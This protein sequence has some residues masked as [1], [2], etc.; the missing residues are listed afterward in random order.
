MESF[1]AQDEAVNSVVSIPNETAQRTVNYTRDI[2]G[3]VLQSYELDLD[4]GL[5]ILSFDETISVNSYIPSGIT[6]QNAANASTANMNY[7]LT[8]GMVNNTDDPVVIIRLMQI[9]LDSLKSQNNLATSQQNTYIALYMAA[10]KD[11]SL[12]NVTIISPQNGLPVKNV[13][14]DERS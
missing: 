9:D 1:T 10:F 12:N 14:Q 2:S 4:E 7:T 5:L 13:I 8:S 11:T 6:L 3:P